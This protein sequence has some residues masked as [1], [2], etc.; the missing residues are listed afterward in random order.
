MKGRKNI[1][2]IDVGKKLGILVR[3]GSRFGCVCKALFWIFL[4]DYW[5][6]LFFLL[7]LQVY[8]ET[9]VQR[10]QNPLFLCVCLVSLGQL[11]EA[12][13]ANRFAD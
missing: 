5:I 10:C 11:W 13:P 7:D 4:I 1:L 2:M 9:T 12:L 8:H 3:L 6:A